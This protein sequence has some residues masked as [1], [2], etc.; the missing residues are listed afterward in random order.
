MT[1]TAPEQ[2]LPSVLSL[3][4]GVQS[5]VLAVM[6]GR[7]LIEPMPVLAVMADTGAETTDTLDRVAWL[8]QALPYPVTVTG[9]A[10]GRTV[11]DALADPHRRADGSRFSSLPLRLPGAQ[12]RR[13]C[14]REFKVEPV[15]QV[16]RRDVLGL[17]PRAWWPRQPAVELWLGITIDEIERARDSRRTAIK[18]R[19]PLIELG[20]SR[21]D[22]V[23]WWRDHAPH[24]A[25]PL[26]KSG[27]T[28]CP[29]RT[30]ADWLATPP[31]VL[32]EIAGIELAG[33]NAAMRDGGQPVGWLH[34]A[35]RPLADAVAADRRAAASEPTL[36]GMD[37]DGCA[38]GGACWT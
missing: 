22:C 28:C 1:T 4:G 18:H 31:D 19:H 17:R 10:D 15:E 21:S 26:G 8:R 24:G 30:R 3:G 25:P 23:A 5:T 2:P 35:A 13:Q 38:D 16:L 9:R 27:C 20:M 33:N 6:A 32:A 12:G 11:L 37:G 14:T 29:Y 7:G 36:P 34:P